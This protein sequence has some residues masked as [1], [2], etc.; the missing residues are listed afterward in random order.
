MLTTI[1]KL[2][3]TAVFGLT[4]FGAGEAAA[5]GGHHGDRGAKMCQRLECTDAQKAQLQE[6]RAA[7]K[8]AMKAER[9]AIRDLNRQLVAEYAK[10]TVDTTKVKSLRAQLDAHEATF[11]GQRQAMKT[12]V[13]A[14]LTPAQRTK[15]AE[16]KAKH[17]DGKGKGHHRGGG[18]GD[19]KGPSARG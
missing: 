14:L 2:V 10:P 5:G 12:K 3:M 15:M 6:L 17:R 4:L 16:F 11:D 1:S 19:R 8:P 13:D 18:R 7:H 9:E